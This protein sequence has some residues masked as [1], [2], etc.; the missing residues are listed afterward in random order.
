MITKVNVANAYM[1]NAKNIANLK[2]SENLNNNIESKEKN[3]VEEIKKS[4]QNGTYKIDL[5]KTAQKIADTL[6]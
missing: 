1:A 5:Q 3:R 4:I 2:K 6:L